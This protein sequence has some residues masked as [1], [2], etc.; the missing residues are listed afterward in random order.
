MAADPLNHILVTDIAGGR[1]VARAA[2]TAQ[3]QALMDL[4]F[5]ASGADDTLSRA[6]PDAADRLALVQRLIAL[7]ALF[8]DGRDWCP[9]ALVGHL[10]DLGLIKTSYRVIAWSGP[11]AF[12]IR[13]ER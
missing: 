11:G 3:R 1:A 13:T 4:G 12:T 9:A 2:T 6:L 8:S 10:K 5:T 7:D